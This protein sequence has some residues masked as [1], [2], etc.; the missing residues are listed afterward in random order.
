MKNPWHSKVDGGSLTSALAMGY[1]LFHGFQ[2]DTGNLGRYDG[3]V[4]G[5]SRLEEGA[6]GFANYLRSSW[7]EGPIRLEY[8]GLSDFSLAY[9]P[10]DAKI[11]E[12]SNIDSNKDGNKAGFSYVSTSEGTSTT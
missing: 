4:K 1:E 10:V 6:V 2:D 11:S 9:F 3:V 7:G 5:V 12:F 8:G